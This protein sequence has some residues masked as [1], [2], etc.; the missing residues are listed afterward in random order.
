[1]YRAPIL[2]T[3]L[4][5]VCLSAAANP[6]Q[7]DYYQPQTKT[8][9]RAAPAPAVPELRSILIIGN[10][11]TAVFNSDSTEKQIGE[12]ISS[13]RIIQIEP[14]YVVLERNGKQTTLKL[15]TTGE[16]QIMP[17]KGE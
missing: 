3:L 4:C 9:K 14:D 2:F 15:S 10:Y 7:P 8:V 12:S 13:Y 5:G 6:M 1:M 17:A 16:L 11:R